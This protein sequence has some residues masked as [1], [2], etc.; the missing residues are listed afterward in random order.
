MEGAEGGEWEGGK[1]KITGLP[2]KR[3]GNSFYHEYL[4]VENEF[5]RV[6][7]F[8]LFWLHQFSSRHPIP[9]LICPQQASL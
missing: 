8:P 6:I 9:L 4:L 2:S 5:Q 1:E 3:Q 7:F